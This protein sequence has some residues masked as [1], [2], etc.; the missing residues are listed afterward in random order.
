ML[1]GIVGDMPDII[2]YAFEKVPAIIIDTAN[3]A[4]IHRYRDR[5]I[6]EYAGLY[7]LQIDSLY[8]FIPT[9]RQLNKLSKKFA[10][11]NIFITTFTKL[12]NYDNPIED[13]DIF[14]YAWELISN[15]ALDKDIYVAVQK[16][17]IHEHL[18]RV[19]GMKTM[20]HT[21]TSQRM[22]ID[23]LLRELQ[24]FSRA[25]DESD[26]IVY[27]EL[28]HKPLTHIGSISYA[29]PLRPEV[30]ILLSIILEQQK[31]INA[32]EQMVD[33]CLQGSGENHSMVQE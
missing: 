16:G 32:Y 15:H 26:R 22:M 19:H 2:S 4:D 6:E 25:L 1:Y 9:L 28:L 5:N 29:S 13:I 12:F 20:G 30:F 7:V 23:Q 8:R 14:I 17:T 10:T 11:K 18:S 3:V 27:N 31:R 33:R 21:I 24:L